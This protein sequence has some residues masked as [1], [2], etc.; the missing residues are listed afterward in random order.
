MMAILINNML[1]EEDIARQHAPLDNEIFAELQW[2]ATSSKNSDSI[3]NLLFDFVSLG[4][5]IG[6][7]L[8][9]FAQT[10]QDK[11]DHHTCPSGTTVI[12]AFSATNFI[13]YDKKHISRI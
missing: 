7:H 9:K 1:R 11:V 10:T 12:K 4:R 6:L 3:S 13:F 5:Y 8:S 2:S